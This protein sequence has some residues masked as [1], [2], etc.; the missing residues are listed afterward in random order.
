MC[1]KQPRQRQPRQS[2]S[3]PKA[4]YR[5]VELAFATSGEQPMASAVSPETSK[6]TKVMLDQLKKLSP[7]PVGESV[8]AALLAVPEDKRELVLTVL[9]AFDGRTHETKTDEA[10]AAAARLVQNAA[11]ELW[12]R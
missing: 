2:R 12:R 4:N 1:G 9:K 5:V 3:T 7:S 11:R 6:A 8:E 10:L